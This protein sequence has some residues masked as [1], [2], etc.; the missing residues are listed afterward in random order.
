MSTIHDQQENTNP[1]HYKNESSKPRHYRKVSKKPKI[2]KTIILAELLSVILACCYVYVIWCHN[3]EM[4]YF[5]EVCPVVLTSANDC[6]DK[7]AERITT[8]Y[9]EGIGEEVYEYVWAPKDVKYRTGPNKS[10]KA[11]GTLEK[12][13]YV[14]RTGIT[15]N[16]WSRITIED[17][18]YYVPR[19]K[20]SDEAPDWLPI[21][22]GAKGEYQKYALSLLPDF[23][24][25]PSELEPLIYLWNKESGW[26]PHSHN[27]RSGAHGIPQALPGSK[28]AS[29]GSDYYTNAE[30]QIRWGLK[31]IANRY[32]SPSNA[33][34]HWC[35]R[36]WY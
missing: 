15:H 31:Y 23:G 30:P 26:N 24:W 12:E 20:L 25:P 8:T 7:Q 27:K 16:G 1:K 6:M 17:K 35:S 18:E 36:G 28:M 14:R 5:G 9:L 11:A 4:R 29:E 3:L 22:S 13:T 10:Y 33:W 2:L 32:G 34:A 21:A 19:G